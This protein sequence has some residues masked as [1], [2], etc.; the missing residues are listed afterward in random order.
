LLVLE[1]TVTEVIWKEVFFRGVEA[2][3]LFGF[4]ESVTRRVSL[5]VR[6]T[7]LAYLAFSRLFADTW[8]APSAM[9][10]Y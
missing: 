9:I 5:V 1:P 7:E 8:L 2:A 6:F 3:R 4:S 10:V